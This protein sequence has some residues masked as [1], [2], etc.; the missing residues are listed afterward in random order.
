MVRCFRK[1]VNLLELSATTPRSLV[2]KHRKTETLL[3]KTG[4]LTERVWVLTRA[5]V[6]NYP[7][8]SNIRGLRSARVAFYYYTSLFGRNG[9]I[10]SKW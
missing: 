8:H 6:A 4:Y 5:I 7:S 1:G 9:P 10:L 2:R 3:D